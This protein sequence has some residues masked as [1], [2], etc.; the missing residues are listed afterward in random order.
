M[1]WIIPFR[2]KILRIVVVSFCLPIF[3]T[4]AQTKLPDIKDNAD[5]IFD[6]LLTDLDDASTDTLKINVLNEIAWHFAPSNFSK[7]I[8]YADSAL[9]LSRKISWKKGEAFALKHKG[10]ALRYSGNLK[11]SLLNHEVALGL[12][13]Q[14]EDKRNTASLLSNI[15]ISYN[16]MSVASLILYIF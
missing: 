4:Y 10:E 2:V 13:E 7:S 15:G 12:F 16:Q 6:S 9:N 8:R 11:K 1:N 5:L 3:S 14:L